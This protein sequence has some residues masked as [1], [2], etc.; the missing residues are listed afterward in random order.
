MK[1]LF[2]K[3]LHAIFKIKVQYAVNMKTFREERREFYILFGRQ[4]KKKIIS[5]N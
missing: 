3:A 5:L 1:N 4:I 2:K